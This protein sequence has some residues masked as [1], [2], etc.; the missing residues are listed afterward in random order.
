MFYVYLMLN[1]VFCVFVYVSFVLYDCKSVFRTSIKSVCRIAIKSMFAKAWVIIF[2]L[3][4][5]LPES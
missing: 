5:Q 3:V 2:L 4:I 1:S